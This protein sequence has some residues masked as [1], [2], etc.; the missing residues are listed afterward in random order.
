MLLHS[1]VVSCVAGFLSCCTSYYVFHIKAQKL[2][3]FVI[4]TSTVLDNTRMAQDWFLFV[5]E[6]FHFLIFY[7]F[8]PPCL[9][10]LAGVKQCSELAELAGHHPERATGYTAQNSGSS[11]CLITQFPRS[12]EPA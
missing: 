2:L 12:R 6:W 10:V 4:I 11:V 8:F 9:S 3:L 5:C 1:V 7:Y